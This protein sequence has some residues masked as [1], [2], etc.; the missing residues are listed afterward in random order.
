MRVCP[1]LQDLASHAGR[2][3]LATIPEAPGAHTECSKTL[4]SSALSP[5][6][7]G[8]QHAPSGAS[9][10]DNSELPGAACVCWLQPWLSWVDLCHG[11]HPRLGWRLLASDRPGS[12]SIP[13]LIF[14][15][16]IMR[17]EAKDS[18]EAETLEFLALENPE[19][20]LGAFG[21]KR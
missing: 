1:H 20:V 8:R 19:G 13:R 5:P 6:G 4:R 12:S 7:R 16:H 3:G 15:S 2:W 21:F 11:S 17:V 14:L 18:P 9:S 10:V